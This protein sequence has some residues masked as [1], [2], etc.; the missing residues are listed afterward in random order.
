MCSLWLSFLTSSPL[1]WWASWFSWSKCCCWRGKKW[2]VTAYVTL[3]ALIKGRLQRWL[4]SEVIVYSLEPNTLQTEKK[5]EVTCSE[6]IERALRYF[7]LE[8][9]DKLNYMTLH[10]QVKH[11]CL[12]GDI[13]LTDFIVLVYRIRQRSSR[14]LIVLSIWGHFNFSC[15]IKDKSHLQM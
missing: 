2:C 1:N 12:S 3:L 14:L 9:S 15:I 7:L 10:I 4:V 8:Q 5:G 13:L 11:G 6:S